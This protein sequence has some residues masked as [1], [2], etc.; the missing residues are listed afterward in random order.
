MDTYI[1]HAPTPVAQ[2][3]IFPDPERE[4][5][6]PNG[7]FEHDIRIEH[8]AHLQPM[9]EIAIPDRPIVTGADFSG[10]GSFEHDLR[11]VVNIRNVN[12]AVVNTLVDGS[13]VTYISTMGDRPEAGQVLS[14]MDSGQDSINIVDLDSPNPDGGFSNLFT[15]RRDAEGRLSIVSDSVEDIR[16]GMAMD[17]SAMQEQQRGNFTL[18]NVL[19]GIKEWWVGPQRRT[20]TPS[21]N[22]ATGYRRW[23]GLSGRTSWVSEGTIAHHVRSVRRGQESLVGA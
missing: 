7:L 11:A 3:D 22:P 1:P 6:D 19:R 17:P 18:R 21:R 23:D 13:E 16:V 15:L 8:R 12:L 5:T 20:P 4:I 2:H 10:A 9:S 14:Y